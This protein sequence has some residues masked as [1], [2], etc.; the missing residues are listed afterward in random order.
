M[1]LAGLCR[2]S[3]Q[4]GQRISIYQS[5]RRPSK[6]VVSICCFVQR[7]EELSMIGEFGAWQVRYRQLE[8]FVSLMHADCR[9]W[10]R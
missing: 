8:L 3:P 7:V 6:K 1:A 9:L 10:R 2:Q 4:L 5:A